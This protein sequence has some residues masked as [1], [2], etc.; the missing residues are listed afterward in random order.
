VILAVVTGLGKREASC[1]RPAAVKQTGMYV[2]WLRIP[3]DEITR[4]IGQWKRIFMKN[5]IMVSFK[6][7][8]EKE[9]SGGK[10]IGKPKFSP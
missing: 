7:M 6:E 1:G 5:K 10:M 3:K 2:V 4:N 8:M 9:S